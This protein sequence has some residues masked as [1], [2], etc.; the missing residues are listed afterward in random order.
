MA[1]LLL[2][3]VCGWVSRHAWVP[4]LINHQLDGVRLTE[5]QGLELARTDQG[6][7]AQ[8][9]HLRL[10]TRDGLS[11]D[12]SGIYVSRLPALLRK[13]LSA[14]TQSPPESDVFVE[15]LALLSTPEST[16]DTGS[17][18]GDKSGPGSEQGDTKVNAQPGDNGIAKRSD[19]APGL[20]L[21]KTLQSLRNLPLH[22]LE[23]R[24][25]RWPNRIDDKFSFSAVQSP[26][27]GIDGELR[28]DR[29][30]KCRLQLGIRNEKSLAKA[31]LNLLHGEGS[32]AQLDTLLKPAIVPDSEDHPAEWQFDSHLVLA[33]EQLPTLVQQIGVQHSKPGDW[34]DIVR[35]L[36]GNLDLKIRGVIPDRF[37]G[38]G[39]LRNITAN[40][41]TGA[42]TVML[43]EEF[44][45]LPL[46]A[47]ITTSQ[48]IN[49]YIH[50]IAPLSV[51]SAEGELELR[52]GSQPAP[53]NTAVVPPLLTGN[54]VLAT[55]NSIPGVQFRGQTQLDEVSRLWETH[56]W[57]DLRGQFPV[58]AMRGSAAFTGGFALPGFDGLLAGTAVPEIRQFLAEIRL[59]G[60]AAFHLDLPAENNPLA[61]INWQKPL[62][63]LNGGP[64]KVSSVQLPGK[65]DLELSQLSFSVQEVHPSQQ[66]S[67]PSPELHGEL[68]KFR[69]S[70]LPTV[71]CTLQVKATI[72]E[73][74]LPNASTSLSKINLVLA[75]AQVTFA[76][77]DRMSIALRELNLS[78]DEGIS[79]DIT[80]GKP[81]LF[82]QQANCQLQNGALSC[83]SP[84]LAV[85]LDPLSMGEDQL[86]GAVFVEDLTLTH[87][88]DQ[89]QNFQAAARFHADS[90]NIR[91]LKQYKAEIATRGQWQFANQQISG[92][93][94]VSGGP[95]T[96][97]ASW[98]HNLKNSHG[99][100][101]LELPQTEFSPKNNLGRSLHG[102]PADI[103]GGKLQAEA[104]LH[105]PS[106]EKDQ[107]QLTFNDTA[108]QR[109]DSFAVGVNAQVA[110]RQDAGKWV[111]ANP[112][113]VSVKS[114]DTGLAVNNMHFLLSLTA[115]G[116]LTLGS[117]SAEL[118]EGALTADKLM[119]NLNGEERHSR[120]QFT[121]LSIGALAKEMESTNFAAS[122]LLDASIPL[123]TDRQGIT[124]DNGTV[125][126]RPPGGRLRYYGAFSPSMLGSNP[127]LKLLAGA[128]EDY[129]YRD[130]SG[131]MSYPLSGDLTLNLKLTGRSAAIDAN[132]DLIIN[133]NLE[134]NVPSMLRSLQASRDLTDVLE[135][136]V[137]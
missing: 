1:L 122:G 85:N 7:S 58:T 13:L 50:A 79:G 11:I 22:K 98:R 36:R 68:G 24:H 70:G 67:G 137:Q 15:Y 4:A 127:Q 93:S 135:R 66:K 23:V 31:T 37:T 117:F 104:N 57:Q 56:K 76:E 110:L 78:A 134:N 125:K 64:I 128:L 26:Q 27:H 39:D 14:S 82:A 19:D 96:L 45:G 21:A 108:L 130:I 97:N 116:D 17:A 29:C 102:L 52:I 75:E 107:L 51:G 55:E 115:D 62:I 63:K 120:L 111:T 123:T 124:V 41:E 101:K 109:N 30:G 43:P 38:S 54:L 34:V 126:S 28:S 48:P 80:I 35:S 65:V 59:D 47:E 5:L 18:A 8:I 46:T 113:P 95:L 40:M 3:A 100:L 133:L 132:R 99:N 86:R 6:I 103:I 89:P 16:T 32:V 114:V 69:C 44:A 90:L 106:S 33:T 84:Q 136:Q 87:H 77:A 71:N 73:L 119:W 105:W 2:V 53:A 94:E 92:S 10:E 20:A 81:E 88:S 118:L 42:L 25:I 74:M 12:L 121:G 9:E 129:N 131:T 72:P 60:E 61:A 83:E 112:V 91:A 49:L